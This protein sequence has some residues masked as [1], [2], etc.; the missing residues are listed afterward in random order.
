MELFILI[1]TNG[2]YEEVMIDRENFLNQCY[3]LIG[4]ELIEI[5]KPN[6]PKQDTDI[7]F[8][9]DESG[10]IND[11]VYN[12]LATV[13]YDRPDIIFGNVLVGKLGINDYGEMDI[14]GLENYESDELLEVLVD[15]TDIVF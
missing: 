3:D 15:L 14:V 12:P 7:R 8:I 1:K 5:C 13:L 4:C 6:F 9:I 10:K 11:Q 2:E